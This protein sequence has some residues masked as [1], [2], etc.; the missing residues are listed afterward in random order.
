[1]QETSRKSLQSKCRSVL[2]PALRFTQTEETKTRQPCPHPTLKAEDCLLSLIFQNPTT[3]KKRADVTLQDGGRLECSLLRA[4]AGSD[5][6][7]HMASERR[8]QTKSCR[9]P[10]LTSSM[11]LSDHG[12]GHVATPIALDLHRGSNTGLATGPVIAGKQA[13]RQGLENGRRSVLH[14]CTASGHVLPESALDF[15]SRLVL[16]QAALGPSVGRLALHFCKACTGSNPAPARLSNKGG[17]SQSE[18]ALT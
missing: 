2:G 14:R 18:K 11:E 3:S 10:P 12:H 16:Q 8:L 7:A 13:A 17:G 15:E 9:M 5:A 4:K 1:M 6:S